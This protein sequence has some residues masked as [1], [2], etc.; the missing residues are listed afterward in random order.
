MITGMAEFWIEYF[1]IP[2]Y[3][4]S[5]FVTS[6]L[7][8]NTITFWVGFFLCLCGG[9]LRAVG[10]IQLGRNFAHRIRVQKS[11]EHKLITT[12]LYS[13]T[14]L[15]IFICS[16]FRHPAYTGWVYFSIGTQVLLNN[17][18][19]IVAYA[20]ASWYFFYRRIPYEESLLLSFFPNYR[21]Y[22][23]KTHIF[24]PFIPKVENQLCLFIPILE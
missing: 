8:V 17:P 2:V 4:Q 3:C 13:F 5:F 7:R 22:R 9:L 16:I 21:A 10:E 20:L 19:C 6:S 23:E 24:I 11:E 12:G 1:L 18:L 15:F 14:S